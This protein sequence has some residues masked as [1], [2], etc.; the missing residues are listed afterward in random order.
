M[1]FNDTRTHC[2]D[3][4][5]V[6]RRYVWREDGEKGDRCFGLDFQEA[7]RQNNEQFEE[8]RQ[9]LWNHLGES[10]RISQYVSYA[11][12][13]TIALTHGLDKW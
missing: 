8:R 7:R 11:Y 3:A 9:S 5:D 10:T 6:T 2:S 1:L 13:A 4:K 12:D